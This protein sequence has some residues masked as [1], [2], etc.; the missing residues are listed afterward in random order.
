M[1]LHVP[2]VL[3]VQASDSDPLADVAPN[4]GGV[5]ESRWLVLE[6]LGL[7]GAGVVGSQI[8]GHVVER[9]FVVV[10]ILLE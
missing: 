7:L 2:H 8:L 1:L 5:G 3:Q 9:C 6:D 4:Q 10:E